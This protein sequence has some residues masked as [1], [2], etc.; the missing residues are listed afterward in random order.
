[1]KK[2][3]T[4]F[5]LVT[6]FISVTLYLLYNAD[7]ERESTATGDKFYKALFA[8]EDLKPLLEEA[9]SNWKHLAKFEYAAKSIT[10]SAIPEA[11]LTY[12]SLADDKEA[13]KVFCELA[14]Y[15]EAMNSLRFRGEKINNGKF[16][17]L[18]VNA[19]YPYSSKEAVAIAKIHNNDTKGASEIL[20]SLLNDGKCPILIKASAQELLQ[21][22]GN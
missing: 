5:V 17:E 10:N 18:V 1:M 6:V 8:G 3:I 4:L 9:H 14:R 22:Y 15:L 11:I 13:P 21:I 7:D 19:A 12:N 16:E 20:Y 2:Y